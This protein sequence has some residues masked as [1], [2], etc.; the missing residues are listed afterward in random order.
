MALSPDLCVVGFFDALNHRDLDAARKFVFK[1]RSSSEVDKVYAQY[2]AAEVSVDA[3]SEENGRAFVTFRVGGLG[4]SGTKSMA[5][6]RLDR[7]AWRLDVS[8]QEA[9]QRQDLSQTVEMFQVAKPFTS[10][11]KRWKDESKV[12]VCLS[13]VG[14]VGMAALQ[15]ALGT[16]PNRIILN[17]EEAKQLR[18]EFLPRTPST[19]TFALTPET[20]KQEIAP[21]LPAGDH[22]FFECPFGGPISLNT[23]LFGHA[24]AEAIHPQ[25]T[26]LAYEG[27]DG[28]PS[29][30][31][32]GKAHVSF[33]FGSAKAV[34][35]REAEQLI[36][37]L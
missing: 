11:M 14:I 25:R 13:N 1:A 3:V 12:A 17:P 24:L 29:F 2:P 16:D 20:W 30:R 27:S 7:G 8:P 23:A 36:W 32:H 6:C 9:D 37:N 15:V 18:P 33:V 19:A 34:D 35:E 26:V 31:H 22:N 5:Y 10:M 4:D 21:H 28:Q